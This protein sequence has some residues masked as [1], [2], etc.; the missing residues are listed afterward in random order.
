MGYLQYFKIENIVAEKAYSW[1]GLPEFENTASTL[2]G[3]AEPELPE[4]KTS[5]Y[6]HHHHGGY[7][8]FQP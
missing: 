1:P 7:Q 4:P 2:S 6:Q 5:Q 8:G 3:A